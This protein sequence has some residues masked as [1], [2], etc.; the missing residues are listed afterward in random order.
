MNSIPA[1]TAVLVAALLGVVGCSPPES[2]FDER[3]STQNATDDQ[4]GTVSPDASGLRRS[5][6]AGS[7]ATASSGAVDPDTGY[8][9]VESRLVDQAGGLS[10]TR[11]QALLDGPDFESRLAEFEIAAAANSDAAAFTRLYDSALRA[12]LGDELPLKRLA[13]GLG[14]CVAVVQTGEDES[15]FQK[16][17]SL[18]FDSGDPPHYVSTSQRVEVAPG[19]FENR[20]L[21]SVDP[22]LNRFSMSAP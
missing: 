19:R 6:P 14:I 11:V 4:L 9:E 22:D 12:Q 21:F 5:V 17:E 2:G 7:H 20:V 1:I 16:W 15:A 10:A 8:L 18:F 3:A 13:C